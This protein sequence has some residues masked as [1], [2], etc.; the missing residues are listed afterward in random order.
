M[1]ARRAPR[2]AGFLLA[3]TLATFTISAFVLLGLVSASS[4]LLQAMDRSIAHVQDVDDLGRT[5]AAITRDVSGLRRA[6]WYGTEP[7]PYVFRGGPNTLFFAHREVGPDGIGETRVIAIREI[8]GGMGTRLVRSEARLPVQAADFDAVDFGPQH[9]LPTGPARLRF[10]YVMGAG[11]GK[12]EQS[13]VTSWPMGPTLPV[14]VIVEAVEAASK[15]L[16]VATRIPIRANADVGCLVGNRNEAFSLVN[17][18]A[19][20]GQFL[21]QFPGQVSSQVSSQ[22]LP[23]AAGQ[24][25]GAPPPDAVASFCGR[26]DKDDKEADTNAARPE[27]TL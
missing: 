27:P 2:N 18:G 26:A 4:V 22:G 3:E 23:G 25:T 21:G 8:V 16:I 10:Y 6:R 7:Q 5:M 14:A 13:R 12:P 17:A 15:R 20:P 24:P 1:G 9:E 11:K 19:A